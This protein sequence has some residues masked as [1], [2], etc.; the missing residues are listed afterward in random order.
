MH[1]SIQLVYDMSWISGYDVVM[2]IFTIIWLCTAIYIWLKQLN[3][4][5]EQTKLS[6]EQK[7][8]T[9]WIFK[10]TE[11]KKHLD[12]MSDV[13]NW[14]SSIEEKRAAKEILNDLQQSYSEILQQ[15]HF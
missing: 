11:T 15:R 10:V 2:M 13:I 14:D 1:R 9:E 7:E 6:K 5:N 12:D 8:L 4:S 3:I